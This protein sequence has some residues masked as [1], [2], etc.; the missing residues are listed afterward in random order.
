MPLRAGWDP[1]ADATA[2]GLSLRRGRIGLVVADTSDGR[3]G[4]GAALAAA[5]GGIRIPVSELA[6]EILL[7]VAEGAR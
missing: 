7:A 6:P 1:S 4:C 2:E 3:S 5:G